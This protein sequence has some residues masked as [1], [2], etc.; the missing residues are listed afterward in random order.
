MTASGETVPAA[1][2]V[3][4]TRLLELLRS[5]LDWNT[6]VRTLHRERAA[7]LSGQPAIGTAVQEVRRA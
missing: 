2:G 7:A 5:G 4:A 1:P 3:G 6:A